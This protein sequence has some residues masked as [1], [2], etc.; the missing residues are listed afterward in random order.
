MIVNSLK[1]GWEII[2]QR[3]HANLAAVILSGWKKSEDIYRP[4]EMI[5]AV[6][7]HDD[8]EILWDQSVHLTDQGAPLDFIEGDLDE[9]MECASLVIANAYRQ[10][11]WIA[12]M[13]SMHHTSLYE[14]Q[15]GT[16]NALDRFLDLQKNNQA[17]WRKQ[18]KI[19]KTV[20]VRNSSLVLFVDTLS[21]ILCRR[22]LPLLSRRLEVGPTPDNQMVTVFQRDDKSIGLDPWVFE[23]S[24]VQFSL[25]TRRLDQLVYKDELELKT[26]LNKAVIEVVTWDFRK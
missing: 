3:A 4:T 22:Q 24:E 25:E 11:L 7:Q 15:R 17:E 18:L 13:I 16:N 2:Y 12:L 26:A 10:G 9:S 21:L 23:E 19:S 6:A 14:P 5:I 8:E 20:A 1:D